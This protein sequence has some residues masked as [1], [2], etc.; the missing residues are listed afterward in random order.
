[1]ISS[2]FCA[3]QVLATCAT[4]GTA[5][6]DTIASIAA[7]SIDFLNLAPLVVRSRSLADRSH[8]I[9]VPEVGEI[10]ILVK[11]FLG[12][13]VVGSGRTWSSAERAGYRE[14]GI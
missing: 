14:P 7:S 11:E 1:M 12:T 9:I 2:E 6:T 8:S 5:T 3:S 13:R 4:A 10:G